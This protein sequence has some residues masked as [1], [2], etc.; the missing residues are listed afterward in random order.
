MFADGRLELKLANG[1]VKTWDE[2]WMESD[3]R[4]PTDFPSV[5]PRPRTRKGTGTLSRRRW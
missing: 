5:P 1:T 4:A 3:A 2:V